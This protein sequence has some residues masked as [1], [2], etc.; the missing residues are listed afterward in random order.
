MF[1]THLRVFSRIQT[2][3]GL[4]GDL[5]RIASA[6][7]DF[8]FRI[9]LLGYNGVI[10]DVIEG[11]FLI[12]PSPHRGAIVPFFQIGFWEPQTDVHVNLTGDSRAQLQKNL[13]VSDELKPHFRVTTILVS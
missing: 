10:D 4:S 1:I 5:R 8:A 6:T 3:H 12:T 11:I 13:Q 7:H 9:N 2:I